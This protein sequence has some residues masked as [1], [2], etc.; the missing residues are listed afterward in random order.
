LLAPMRLFPT[1]IYTF[2]HILTQEVAYQSLPPDIR[3]QTHRGIAQ[4]L[5]EQFPDLATTQPEVLA[6]HYTEAGLV[7]QAV[8]YWQRAGQHASDR[9]AHLEAISHVTRGITLLTT[10]PE[11]PEHLQ[12]ALSL[13]LAMGAALLVT[14]G[15]AAP[16]VE[17]A[18]TQ[19]HALCQRV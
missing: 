17:R 5:V 1:P 11:T 3:R 4:V 2:K 14:K 9:S 10:L 8:A 18:Y 13:H 16:E 19:A 7:A 12:Q 6:Q 15:H